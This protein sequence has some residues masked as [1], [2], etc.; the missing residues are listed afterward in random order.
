MERQNDNRR[1]IRKEL[2]RLFLGDTREEA[3]TDEV[4]PWIIFTLDD[5]EY[6]VNSKHVES[7]ECIGEITPLV[8]AKH[9]CPGTTRFRGYTVDLLDLR[10]LL[11]IGDYSTTKAKSRNTQTG[12]LILETGGKIRGVLVDEIVSVEY[13]TIFRRNTCDENDCTSMIKSR[14]IKHVAL[15]DKLLTPVQLL[16]PKSL[17]VLK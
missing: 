6:G 10:A 16:D 11:G 1:E 13:M 14:Y 2:R 3:R 17:C 5:I 8:G 15:R 4:Y 9:Y 12:M 7:I